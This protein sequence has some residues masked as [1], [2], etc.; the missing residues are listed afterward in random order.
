M[1]V[2]KRSAY[3]WSSIMKKN[4]T[5]LLFVCLTFS[6]MSKASLMHYDFKGSG[7]STIN[8]SITDAVTAV[9][10]HVLSNSPATPIA[11]INVGLNS[12]ENSILESSTLVGSTPTNSILAAGHYTLVVDFLKVPTMNN[13]FSLNSN[14]LSPNIGISTLSAFSASAP[15]VI[16]VLAGA[17]A[18]PGDPLALDNNDWVVR[19]AFHTIQVPEPSTVILIT[20]CLVLLI[21]QRQQ[22]TKH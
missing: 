18:G 7:F 5:L 16:D 14:L 6:G 21:S 10:V 12:L 13:F 9:N 17:I 3:V 1:N 2:L 11:N 4:L 8:L 20:I 19:L 22:R 15:T